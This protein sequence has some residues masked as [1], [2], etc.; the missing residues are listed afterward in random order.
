MKLSGFQ[1]AFCVSLLAHGA[2]LSTYYVIKHERAA[3]RPA[4]A[5]EDVGAVEMLVLPEQTEVA[6]PEVKSPTVIVERVKAD[7]PAIAAAPPVKPDTDLLEVCEA[8]KEEKM[9]AED[10]PARPISTTQT[11]AAPV[12][13]TNTSVASASPDINR[14]RRPRYLV[15]PKPVYPRKALRR[16]EEGL[17]LLCVMVTTEGM[18]AN[19]EMV[20]SSGYSLLDDAAVAAVKNWQ[21]IPA[22][23]GNIAIASNVEIPIRFRLSP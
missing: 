2:I 18:P 4:F 14:G 5:I 1:F 6:K 3:A 11:T 20:Q 23:I 10:A 9:I 22:R 8:L 16:R 17:V 15:C 21:F 19:V 12:T 13:A 7:P